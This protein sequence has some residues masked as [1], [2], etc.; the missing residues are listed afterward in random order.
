MQWPTNPNAVGYLEYEQDVSESDR[1]VAAVGGE[2]RLG[3]GGRVYGR[4][5][6]LSSLGS[7]YSLN[8][9][10]R[11]YTGLFGFDTQYMK[12]G[13]VFS[14]Y[15]MNDAMD[16]RSAQAA[17]GLRNLWSVTDSWR[18]GT[19]FEST[20][21]LFGPERGDTGGYGGAFSMPGDYASLNESSVAGTVAAEY[22]GSERMKFST[23]L[24]ARRATSLDSYLHSC[25]RTGCCC[26]QLEA[27]T[28]TPATPPGCASRSARPTARWTT[29]ASIS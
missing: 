17:V 21:P 13:S 5:E 20:R 9:T 11:R 6:F 25:R 16:G 22:V 26:G 27:A 19:T 4:Y 8:D 3:S 29:T 12:D 7:L 28:A 10:Q 23:R 18:L 1:R 15:R 14:E 24:E 2:Y